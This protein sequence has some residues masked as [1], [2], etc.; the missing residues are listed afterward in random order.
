[1]Y[2]PTITNPDDY[3]PE[4]ITPVMTAEDVSDQVFGS[5]VG[6]DKW[7]AFVEAAMSGDTATLHCA[8]EL[9]DLIRNIADGVVNERA[10]FHGV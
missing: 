4:P 3:Q 8:Q 9:A 1:M 7:H 10:H 6:C 2:N 5:N